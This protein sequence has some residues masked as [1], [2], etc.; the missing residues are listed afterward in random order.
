MKA[1]L[2]AAVIILAFVGGLFAGYDLGRAAVTDTKESREHWKMELDLANMKSRLATLERIGVEID[3]NDRTN[4][5][6]VLNGKVQ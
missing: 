4:T 2:I 5:W 3:V 6:F 1:V